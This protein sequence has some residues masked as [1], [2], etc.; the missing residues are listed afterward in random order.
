MNTTSIYAYFPSKCRVVNGEFVKKCS[1]CNIEKLLSDF[2]SDYKGGHS[3]PYIQPSCD[4]CIFPNS[5][6]PNLSKKDLSREKYWRANLCNSYN[7]TV[8]E[9]SQMLLIQ[10]GVC[11]ICKLP[12]TRIMNGKVMSLCIDHNHKT[13]KVRGLL[14][15]KCNSAIGNFF[16]DKN[17]LMSAFQYLSNNDNELVKSDEEIEGI[18]DGGRK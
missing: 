4:K 16:D 11:A 18:S 15:A 13:N 2:Y 1:K 6:Y 17:L 10:N 9:Y 12:E 7:I 8:E 14:C 3:R 5:H